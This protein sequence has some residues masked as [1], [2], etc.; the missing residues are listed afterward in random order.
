M[1][2]G[3]MYHR[4]KIYLYISIFIYGIKKVGYEWIYTMASQGEHY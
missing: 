4:G 2:G 3:S 1:I